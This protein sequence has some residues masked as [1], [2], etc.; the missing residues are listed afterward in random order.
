MFN[1]SLS[2]SKFQGAS[3]Y[4]YD[5]AALFFFIFEICK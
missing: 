2:F 3:K 4:I 5:A 1:T